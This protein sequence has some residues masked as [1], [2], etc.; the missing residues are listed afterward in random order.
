[1][2]FGDILLRMP[3]MS[4]AILRGKHGWELLSRWGVGFCNATNVL[5]RSDVQLLHLVRSGSLMSR[6]SYRD[7]IMPQLDAVAHWGRIILS[8][9]AATCH[10]EIYI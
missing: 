9:S 6:F 3:D 7:T 5:E 2:F 8:Q 10:K 1:M 4:D